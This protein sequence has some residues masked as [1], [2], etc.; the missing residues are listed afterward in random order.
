MGW[1]SLMGIGTNT[2]GG[3]APTN[4]FLL[5]EDGSYILLETGDKIILEN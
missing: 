5:L 2:S 4:S 3:V 1:L